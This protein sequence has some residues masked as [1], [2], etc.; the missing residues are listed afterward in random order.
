MDIYSHLI[1][2]A[3]A[4]IAEYCTLVG[5]SNNHCFPQFW[6]PEVQDEDVDRFGFE[7]SLLG[8][9]A[10][11]LQCPYMVFP[12]VISILGMSFSYKDMSPIRIGPHSIGRILT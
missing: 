4:A 7:A 1:L 12:L 9:E 5:I 8:L 3:R 2:V 6:K 11:F 10:T